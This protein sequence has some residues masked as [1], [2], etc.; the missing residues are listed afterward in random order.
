MKL[1]YISLLILCSS[2]GVFVGSKFLSKNIIENP[3]TQNSVKSEFKSDLINPTFGFEL[4]ESKPNPKLGLLENDLKTYLNELRPHDD[5]EPT[6]IF[7]RELNYGG[8]AFG[9]HSDLTFA[10]ASL[11][12]LPLMMAYFKHAQ[13]NPGFLQKTIRYTQNVGLN[14]H[15]FYTAREY[16]EVGKE[17]TIEQL[18]EYMIIHSDN[19]ATNLLKSFLDPKISS[20]TYEELGIAVPENEPEAEFMTVRSYSSFFRILYNSTYLND[21][22]S[23]KALEILTRSDFKLALRA[24]LPENIRV[25]HKFG[26]RFNLNTNSKQLHDCGI[27]YF[28]GHPYTLCVMTKGDDFSTQAK[29]ISDISSIV[30]ERVKTIYAENDKKSSNVIAKK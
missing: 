23:A 9:I 19:E 16:I 27:I 28:P 14:M 10:P 26:E 2:A 12:K 24:Q 18:I 21:E 20:R 4:E 11:F 15:E 1:A 25:A 3:N 5:H 13:E 6:G 7:F 17:Y 8:T 22:Y 30:F 29:K